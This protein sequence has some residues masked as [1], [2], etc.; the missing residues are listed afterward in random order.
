MNQVQK[1]IK[2]KFSIEGIGVHSGEHAIINIKP[3]KQNSGIVI[4][5]ILFP[6]EPMK[7]G[8][9]RPQQ[10]MHATVL[11]NKSWAV[12]T[13][14]H[15]MAAIFGL[16]IDNLLIEIKGFEVPILDGSALPFVQAITNIGITNQEEKKVFIT[17][18]KIINLKNGD[19]SLQITPAKKNNLELKIDYSVEFEHP[20]VKSNS[21]STTITPDFFSNEISPARTF[22]FLEQLPAL[23]KHGLAKGATLGNTVVVGEDIFLNTLRFENEFI[24]H[25]VLDLIGDLSLLGKN[26]AGTIKAHKTG[27]NF[28]R[29]VIEHFLDNP[30]SWDYL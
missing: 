23:R 29:L 14:E 5:N 2:E 10:A 16:E 24:R 8:T 20:L 18:K 26:L 22:G 15:L 13:I 12:S 25:K 28:N 11:K 30:D 9:I 19:R 6:D 21:W 7:I 3:A 17:P 27:H 4:K 1:T